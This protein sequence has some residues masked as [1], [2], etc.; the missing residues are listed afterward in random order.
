M[1]L[2]ITMRRL[3]WILAIALAPALL[4][5][6]QT[7]T[8]QNSH[9]TPPPKTTA[10]VRQLS[11][12][13]V[14]VDKHEEPVGDLTARDF[15]LEQDGH[16]KT[17]S[18]L[19][20]G[21]DWPLTVG[22]VAETSPGESQALSAERKEGGAFLKRLLRSGT[23]RAFV[24]HFDKQ[25]EL[26]QDVTGSQEKLDRGIDRISGGAPEPARKDADEDRPLFFFGG[27]TLYDAIFLSAD[28]VLHGWGA[29]T[30]IIVFSSGVDRQSKV[31]LGRAIEA[32]QRSGTAV[33]CV[34]V[35]SKDETE[36]D[37]HRN[38]EV[39][40]GGGSYPGGGYPRS[41]LPGHYPGGYPGGQSPFPGGGTVPAQRPSDETPQRVD[42]RKILQQIAQETGGGYFEMKN[43]GHAK[44]IFEAIEE[45][46]RHQ[47][48]LSYTSENTDSG[49][50]R[51]KV[52]TEKQKLTVQAPAALYVE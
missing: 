33:Y 14:V 10:T 19:S 29:R 27:N 22:I 39:D 6:Q 30:T 32:A 26:L 43:E 4:V 49:F 23:D 35:P 16:A 40:T 42:G 13:A 21:G 7:P 20:R 24:L 12:F 25:V 51:L 31:S 2:R 48:R 41:P 1:L 15:V 52:T 44:R 9:P 8:L 47:Y 38:V 5:A 3:G 37:R 45:Q 17:I 36:Q 11:L 18:Q 28:E 50:H 46:L 34:Y